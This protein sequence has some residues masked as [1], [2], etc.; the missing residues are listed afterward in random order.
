[1]KR[2]WI[3]FMVCLLLCG[4]TL[5]HDL[6]DLETRDAAVSAAEEYIEA[7]DS[8]PLYDFWQAD[9]YAA[10]D[11][12]IPYY[13]A[14]G[15]SFENDT[16]HIW[17]SVMSSCLL[18]DPYVDRASFTK[19][20][21]HTASVHVHASVPDLRMLDLAEAHY[22]VDQIRLY[23]MNAWEKRT[24][25]YTEDVP[26]ERR[27]EFYRYSYSSAAKAMIP[28]LEKQLSD[29]PMTEQI[30]TLTLVQT[31]DTWSVTDITCEIYE[32]LASA[33]ERYHQ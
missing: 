13:E 5:R 29:L 15:L 14:L 2:V 23:D 20:G 22:Q 1:M 24:G 26:P 33:L 9:L 31:G 17:D 18:K 19:T 8:A 28:L 32:A 7:Y 4:C 25:L 30:L 16:D 21:D 6:E 10:F 27:E 12:F 3:L 11:L